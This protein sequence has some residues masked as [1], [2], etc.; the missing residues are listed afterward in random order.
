M[1][2]KEPAFETAFLN[3]I[4]RKH[5]H[6]VKSERCEMNRARVSVV[7]LW[8]ASKIF[9]VARVLPI[10]FDEGVA[11]TVVSPSPTCTDRFSYW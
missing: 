4:N 9:D 6:V 8:G 2:N 5:F 11:E 7:S 10:R 1:A 3:D